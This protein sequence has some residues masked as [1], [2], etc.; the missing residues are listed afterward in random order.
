MENRLKLF[1]LRKKYLAAPRPKK[2]RFFWELNKT[3]QDAA[4]T[5]ERE[6]VE[7]FD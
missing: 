6:D 7:R 2:L 5:E 1:E 3:A 4:V